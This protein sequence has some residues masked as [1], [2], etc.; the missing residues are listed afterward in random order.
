VGEQKNSR[1][2]ARFKLD[3]FSCSESFCRAIFNSEA[4]KKPD[5]VELFGK[6]TCMGAG[7]M[8][9]NSRGNVDVYFTQPSKSLVELQDEAKKSNLWR[10]AYHTAYKPFDA[11]QCCTDEVGFSNPTSQTYKI[12]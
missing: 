2:F 10:N 7:F 5:V 12:N 9:N 11:T 8:V 1:G 3:R 4:G 6:S